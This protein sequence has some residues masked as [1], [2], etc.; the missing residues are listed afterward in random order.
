M[1][2]LILFVLSYLLFGGDVALG[3]QPMILDNGR[4]PDRADKS[5]NYIAAKNAIALTESGGN[6]CAKNKDTSASGK[7]QFMRAWN[8]FFLRHYGRSWVSVVPKCKAARSVKL[9]MEKHQ[10]AMFDIYYNMHAGPFIASARRKTRGWNDI[11]LLALYHRQGEAGAWRYIRTGHDYANGKWG[12][13]HVRVHIARV[14][15]NVKYQLIADGN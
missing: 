7:Y 4:L 15:K 10:D 9:R 13:S 1:K 5:Q 8:A 14:L 2:L 6:V 3:K 12:N 11:Q